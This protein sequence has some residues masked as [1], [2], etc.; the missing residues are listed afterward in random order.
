MKISRLLATAAFI[1]CACGQNPTKKAVGVASPAK[2]T[3]LASPLE[4]TAVATEY[5]SW[6][7]Q[8]AS[9]IAWGV[10]VRVRNITDKD[11][12]EV[13]DGGGLHV[14]NASGKRCGISSSFAQVF[15]EINLKELYRQGLQG[16]L[17]FLA[18][19][20]S[21]VRI[22]NGDTAIGQLTSVI[23]MTK[24]QT[25]YNL[26][27]APGKSATLVFVFDSPQDS[28]PQTLAWP[29]AKPIDLL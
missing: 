15:A 24:K 7:A 20:D 26:H 25:N 19:G 23:D 8:S 4:I 12:S 5:A 13:V 9:F 28:R 2:R 17:L 1:A 3:Q 22:L 11:V 16:A 18:S 27:L 10:R 21:G 29:K 14:T 6:Q